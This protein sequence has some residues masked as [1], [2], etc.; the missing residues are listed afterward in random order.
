MAFSVKHQRPKSVDKAVRATVQ[1][2]SYL[3]PKGWSAQVAKRMT[4][5][6]PVAAVRDQDNVMTLLQ[7]M[8][9]LDQLELHVAA[10]QARSK[11]AQPPAGWGAN[12]SGSKG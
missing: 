3:V 8:H 9:R 12:W 2:E 6:E 5:P 11:A 7:V 10:L 1:I 4:S